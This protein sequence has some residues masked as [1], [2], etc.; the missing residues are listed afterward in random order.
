MKHAY[1][2]LEIERKRRG[3]TITE[4]AVALKVSP[5]LISQIQNGIITPAAGLRQ[6]FEE[7]FNCSWDYLAQD[8][9]EQ[10]DMEVKLVPKKSTK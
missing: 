4:M 9:M 1:T 8:L 6:Q 5:S 7:Y 10:S 3:Y 2:I